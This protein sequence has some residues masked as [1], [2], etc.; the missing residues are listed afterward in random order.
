M[1]VLSQTPQNLLEGITEPFPVCC[2][3]PGVGGGSLVLATHLP[4]TQAF[5]PLVALCWDHTISYSHP[6]QQWAEAMP[7]ILWGHQ[8]QVQGR[9]L[10]VY[11]C[12]PTA[13]VWKAHVAKNTC[14]LL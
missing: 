5:C 10:R 3:A 1:Q 7:G 12:Q 13:A 8:G 2:R 11:P 4:A 9:L 14:V 6:A